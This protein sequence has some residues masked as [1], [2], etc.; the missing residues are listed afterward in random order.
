MYKI[1]IR[2]N[3][4]FV[5]GKKSRQLEVVAEWFNVDEN[6]SATYIASVRRCF[7]VQMI[8]ERRG[9]SIKSGIHLRVNSLI[10]RSN[11]TASLKFFILLQLFKVN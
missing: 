8:R 10:I 7:P 9:D 2:R 3:P 1:L 4:C 11:V 5:L 6:T